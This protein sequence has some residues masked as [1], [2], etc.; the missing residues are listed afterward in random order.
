MTISGPPRLTFAIIGDTH[1]KPETNGGAGLWKVND[2][3]TARARWVAREIARYSPRFVVHMGDLVHPVPELPTFDASIALTKGIL[4]PYRQALHIIPGNHDIGDKPN[5]TMPAK[6]IRADWLRLHESNFGATYSRFD[7]DDFCFILLNAPILNSG[8]PTERAQ[9]IWLADTLASNRGKRVFLFMHYPL[10]LFDPAEP[11]HYD[12]IDEPARSDLLEA[13]RE[14]QIEAVFAGHV[15]HIFYHRIDRTEFYVMPSTSFVRQDF[16][17]MFRVEAIHENGRNDAEKLGF[18]IV[19][20]Y[21]D[22]H[23]VHYLRSYGMTLSQDG[24]GE[25][26]APRSTHAQFSHPK[27]P[28]GAPLGVFLRHPWAETATLPHNGPMDEFLR[29]EARNDYQ[30][31]A[32][33]RMGLR[34]ARV[35]LSDLLN[36]TT[37]K[38]MADLVEI[39]HRFTVFGFGIPEGR[40]AEVL[41]NHRDLVDSYECVIPSDSIPDHSEAIRQLR[42]A[43]DRPILLSRVAT[44]ADDPGSEPQGT[45]FVS[46]GFR[47]NEIA[48]IESLLAGGACEEID[49]FVIR[50]VMEDD[51]V[52]LADLLSAWSAR[53]KHRLDLHLRIGANNPATNVTDERAILSSVITLYSAALARPEIT[54]FLDTFMDVD[55]GY[56]VRMGLID[57]RCNLRSPGL[58]LEAMSAYVTRLHGPWSVLSRDGSAGRTIEL[59][60]CRRAALLVLPAAGMTMDIDREALGRLRLDG[61]G[62][63]P[64]PLDEPWTLQPQLGS[65]PH[66]GQDRIPSRTDRPLM[67]VGIPRAGS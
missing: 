65:E 50:A 9:R 36:A 37:R 25:K 14:H 33:W 59:S 64:V 13:I 30:V 66:G 29:K 21:A 7:V 56:C 62:P 39:G 58:A 10:F 27:K 34:L 32:L 20:V 3:A 23:A 6:T 67:L 5:R 54:A 45:L 1:I 60:G 44:S 31:A 28:G 42:R 12:N 61:A 24:A 4:D 26:P 2:L 52:S 49:G 55:R 63:L 22:G 17:E 11:G 57:R 46:H 51:L 41:R 15:H 40:A 16:A 47:P 19:D 18:A 35:P 43:L 8:L 38:R 48:Q 53:H